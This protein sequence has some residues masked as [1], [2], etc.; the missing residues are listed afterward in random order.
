MLKVTVPT[1]TLKI[2]QHRMLLLKESLR[3]TRVP[4]AAAYQVDLADFFEPKLAWETEFDEFQ[5][6]QKNTVMMALC[7]TSRLWAGVKSVPETCKD[8]SYQVW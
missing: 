8:A 2:F 1:E 4:A 3:Q 6:R 7:S 5:N